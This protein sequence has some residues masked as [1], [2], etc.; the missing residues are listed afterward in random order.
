MN[1]KNKPN[2]KKAA[3]KQANAAPAP[4][5][6]K[7]PAKPRGDRP[8]GRLMEFGKYI[9]NQNPTAFFIEST[10]KTG[11]FEVIAV[12]DK[13][14]THMVASAPNYDIALSMLRTCQDI[15]N[16]ELGIDPTL[17]WKQ[18]DGIVSGIWDSYFNECAATANDRVGLELVQSDPQRAK[19]LVDSFR[20][21][22]IIRF[23]LFACTRKDIKQFELLEMGSGAS[24]FIRARDNR[25][26]MHLCATGGSGDEVKMSLLMNDFIKLANQQYA[27]DELR[28]E[29]SAANP[30]SN[31]PASTAAAAKPEPA[32]AVPATDAEKKRDPL[33]KWKRVMKKRPKPAGDKKEKEDEDTDDKNQFEEYSDYEEDGFIGDPPPAQPTTEK[34]KPKEEKKPPLPPRNGLAASRALV[35]DGSDME[36]EDDEDD[37]EE[38]VRLADP[39]VLKKQAQKPLHDGKLTLDK[40]TE[41][42]GIKAENFTICTGTSLPNGS[43]EVVGVSK[44][45]ASGE[46]KK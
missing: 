42:A 32:A 24:W 20:T 12:D 34:E 4:V 31:K 2:N 41:D 38:F 6:P 36:D 44:G 33:K 29:W 16:N 3:P 35:T 1:N 39:K 28:A 15:C 22:P 25:G 11:K 23:G 5:A 40:P 19:N 18:Y 10:A 17:P 26:D 30:D 8:P 14:A 7:E 9:T 27:D 13:G 43:V 37:A 45:D 21:E 46:I